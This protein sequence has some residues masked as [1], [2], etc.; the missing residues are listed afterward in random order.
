MKKAAFEKIVPASGFSF[1]TVHF[2]AP[3]ICSDDFWHF[4]PECEIV[5]V[6]HGNGKRFIGNH[7]SR[8]EDGELIFLGPN[9]PHNTFYFGFES[10]NYEEYVIQFKGQQ[11]EALGALF[12]EFDAITT[13]L[14][15][16]QACV[17]IEGPAKHAIGK[18]VTEMPSLPPFER[19]LQLV[20]VLQQMAV[21]A[22][23]KDLQVKKFLT[24]SM[25]NTQR[26]R[27]VYHIIQQQY[28]TDLTTRG[29]AKA[30]SMTETS[31]CRFFLQSTGKTFKQALTEVRIQH[32]SGLLMNSN[33]T[34]GS[35]AAECGFNSVSLFNRFFRELTQETPNA[36]RKRFNTRVQVSA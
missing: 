1:S 35:I 22:G 11:M 10:D 23:R 17:V 33:A 21:S 34:I 29:V 9:I 25:A 31:F 2:K 24:V 16:A 20:Q 30:L 27:E 5:Y 4:H 15:D 14:E 36:Y 32:A 13:I 3:D 7:I 18:L 19:L 6:P 28:H 26:V 8:F 12:H